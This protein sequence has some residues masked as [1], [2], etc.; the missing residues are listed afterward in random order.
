MVRPR[1]QDSRHNVKTY[2][3]HNFGLEATA[4]A[5]FIAYREEAILDLHIIQVI[6][7]VNN[8]ASVTSQLADGQGAPSTQGDR[9]STRRAG[10]LFC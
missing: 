3:R 9:R 7:A 8:Y 2:A 4:L 1:T 5:A 6:N 10:K